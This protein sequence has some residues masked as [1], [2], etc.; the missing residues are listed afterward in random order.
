MIVKLKK[1][2]KPGTSVD[3]NGGKWNAYVSLMRS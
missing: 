3:D 2:W 1:R